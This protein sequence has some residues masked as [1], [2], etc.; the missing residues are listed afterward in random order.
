MT[1][2]SWPTTASCLPRISAAALVSTWTRTQLPSPPTL[3]SESAG[4]SGINA[5]AFLRSIA[6]SETWEVAP[7]SVNFSGSPMI[8]RLP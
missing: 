4:R 1:V 7:S 3:A 5:A 8:V 6:M 2:V